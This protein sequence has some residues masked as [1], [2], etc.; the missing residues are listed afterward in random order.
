VWVHVLVTTAVLALARQQLPPN[1]WGDG[2]MQRKQ[3]ETAKQ[4]LR[5]WHDKAI[6][7]E[8][9]LSNAA[10]N[11]DL[12][13]AAIVDQRLYVDASS[14]G[15]TL[16]NDKLAGWYDQLVHVLRWWEQHN[17]RIP[18]CLFTIHFRSSPIHT[19]HPL[20]RAPSFAL[21]TSPDYREVPVPNPYFL[22]PDRWA[23]IHTR[24]LALAR[25]Q[26][27]ERR[28][29]TGF[30]RGGC[31]GYPGSVPRVELA[32]IRNPLLDV[33]FYRPCNRTSW[34]KAPP[35]LAA[36][37]RRIRKAKFV[38]FPGFVQHK[39]QIHMPG[40]LN[41]SYS[42]TLQFTLGLGGV[43]LKWDNPYE[44]FYYGWLEEGKHYVV[45]NATTIVPTIVR[46][47]A[48]PALGKRMADD[49]MRWFETH[50]HGGV[51]QQY[52]WHVLSQYS[53]MQEFEPSLK[54]LETPCAC[55]HAYEEWN[56]TS[57]A[58]FCSWPL[59]KFQLGFPDEKNK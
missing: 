51:L 27:F 36:E 54:M 31:L 29:S 14:R 28:R 25:T 6:T 56:G 17:I 5:F 10:H 2:E 8:D 1:P 4:A 9:V 21:A 15:I 11:G 44:E 35:R 48:D 34:N 45:V 42:R 59:Y 43:I 40:G 12:V 13:L 39:Y 7:A 19:A 49:T 20:P 26:P 24:L 57:C 23:R 30:Y 22:T 18:N 52:W 47:N 58:S 55:G 46:L 3:S 33:G 38:S 50:L 41:A 32:A 16:Y 53:S 37:A